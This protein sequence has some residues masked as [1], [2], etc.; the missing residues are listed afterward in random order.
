METCLATRIHHIAVSRTMEIVLFLLDLTGL[1]DCR[2]TTIFANTESNI[3]SIQK[4]KEHHQTRLLQTPSSLVLN[5]SRGG[6]TCIKPT[7]SYRDGTTCI[8][9][10]VSC[11]VE[12]LTPFFGPADS[13]LPTGKTIAISLQHDSSG[14][15]KKDVYPGGARSSRRKALVPVSKWHG[16]RR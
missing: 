16:S 3:Y 9:P 2:K 8:K 7:V 15:H 1:S 13:V 4:P 6:T 14:S 12:C 10:T 11:I 5:T